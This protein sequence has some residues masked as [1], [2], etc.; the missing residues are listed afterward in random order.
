MSDVWPVSAER[1]DAVVLTAS[2]ILGT[3]VIVLAGGQLSQLQSRH[4][5]IRV[6]ILEL[7]IVHFCAL[8]NDD[9]DK[10]LQ[11]IQQEKCID[12]RAQQVDVQ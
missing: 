3:L 11:M 7:D 10:D 12:K 5:N 9:D 1:V 4:H 6:V 2:V 8:E